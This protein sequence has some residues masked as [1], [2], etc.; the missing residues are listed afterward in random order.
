MLVLGG[1]PD[2]SHLRC[3]PTPSGATAALLAPASFQ[4][5]ADEDRDGFGDPPLSPNPFAHCAWIHTELAR[6]GELR[7]VE[8]LEGLSELLGGHRHGD[9]LV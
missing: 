3:G 8:A 2:G 9:G 6:S 1:S 7:E 4:P 5:E